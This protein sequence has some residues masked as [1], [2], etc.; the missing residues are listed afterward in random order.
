MSVA[1]IVSAV[2]TVVSV[3]AGSATGTGF[4]LRVA[5]FFD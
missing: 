1:A 5:F 4:V 2:A 3:A